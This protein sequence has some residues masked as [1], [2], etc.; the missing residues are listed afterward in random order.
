MFYS[1]KDH[2]QP[3]IKKEHES[4]IPNLMKL[5]RIL[6]WGYLLAALAKVLV[7]LLRGGCKV[8]GISVGY[9]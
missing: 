5:S 9:M 4:N 1:G 2:N 6:S 7:G 3:S 8:G